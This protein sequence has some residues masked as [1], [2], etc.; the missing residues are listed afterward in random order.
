MSIKRG[1]KT[2]VIKRDFYEK[3][4]KKRKEKGGKKKAI[5]DCVCLCTCVYA[6]EKCN[7]VRKMVLKEQRFGEMR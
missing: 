3:K 5:F 1:E 6:C 7:E 4:K 2:M